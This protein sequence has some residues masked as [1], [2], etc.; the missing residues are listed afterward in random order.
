[1]RNRS[2]S[3]FG[4]EGWEFEPLRTY[5][6]GTGKPVLFAFHGMSEFRRPIRNS[7]KFSNPYRSEGRSADTRSRA[8]AGSGDADSRAKVSRSSPENAGSHRLAV[9][10]CPPSTAPLPDRE[11]GGGANQ[12]RQPTPR[13]KKE[14]AEQ[15]TPELREVE[16]E[17]EV[18]R[19]KIVLEAVK[20]IG[21]TEQTYTHPQRLS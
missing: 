15:I 7:Q 3:N 21:V 1:M 4:T 9:L 20:K 17:V 13:G 11:S 6:K 2:A 19:G 10:T 12:G 5:C 16:V 8:S 14:L 18:A